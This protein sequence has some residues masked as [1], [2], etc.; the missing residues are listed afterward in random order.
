MSYDLETYR[1]VD[2]A[3]TA[4][5]NIYL[6][7][8]DIDDLKFSLENAR[9]ATKDIDFI[10]KLLFYRKGV[11]T[12]PV[13]VPVCTADLDYVA[14]NELHGS[15]GVFSEAGEILELVEN[16]I[17]KGEEIEREKVVDEVGDLLWYVAMLLREVDVSFEEVA[18]LNIEK[19]RKRFPSKF[20]EERAAKPNHGEEQL[21]FSN[22]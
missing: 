22:V 13:V 2:S 4:A 6:N 3:R 7:E 1:T 5:G 11:G 10:K 21:V 12:N 9:I 16:A 20:E 19:L 14:D 18:R 8:L 15:L 17:F